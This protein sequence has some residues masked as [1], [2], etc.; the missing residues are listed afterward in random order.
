MA[1]K[2]TS[3]ACRF[4]RKPT[5]IKSGCN[6]TKGKAHDDEDGDD[7]ESTTTTT[8]MM[9]M[10]TIIA[11]MIAIIYMAIYIDHIVEMRKEKRR[12]Q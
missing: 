3:V 11:K 6:A 8:M 5:I 12:N 7:D 4:V 1:P 9:M 2:S 10:I